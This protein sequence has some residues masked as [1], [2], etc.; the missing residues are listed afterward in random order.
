MSNG[1]TTFVESKMCPKGPPKGGV[2]FP[3][4]I[5]V[6][7]KDVQ[8]YLE[9]NL[10]TSVKSHFTPEARGG[11]LTFHGYKNVVLFRKFQIVPQPSYVS[12]KC[13]RT[14]EYPDYFKLDADHGT[15]PQDGFCQMAYLKNG[16]QSTDYQ[17]SVDLFN[18]MGWKGVN[19]GHLGVFF[20]AEDQDNYDFVF[21]RFEKCLF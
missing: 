14:V 20:N 15:W 21:F 2:W 17:L 5:E 10:V 4:S 13:A 8:V 19:S 11:A 9:G 1:S 12:K 16:G 18:V 3:V 7:D 6:H